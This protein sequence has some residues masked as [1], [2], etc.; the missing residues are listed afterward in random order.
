MF[1]SHGFHK[2]ITIQDFLL[3]DKMVNLHIKRRRWLNKTTKEV[4]QRNWNL[5]VQGSLI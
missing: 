5:L 2:E 4:V 3:R 1:I